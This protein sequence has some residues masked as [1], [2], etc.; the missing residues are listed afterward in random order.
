VGVEFIYCVPVVSAKL[1]YIASVNI[2]LH[3]QALLLTWQNLKFF[4][5]RYVCNVYSIVFLFF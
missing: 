5:Y 4:E 3:S 2:F 1:L